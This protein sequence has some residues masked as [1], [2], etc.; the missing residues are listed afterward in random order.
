[1]SFSPTV[2]M[3]GIQNTPV[4]PVQNLPLDFQSSIKQGNVDLVTGLITQGLSVNQPLPNGEMPLHFAVRL[5]KPDVALTLLKLG[6]DPEIKDFQHLSAIDHAALMKNESMLA[7]I[8]GYKI[9]KDLKEVQEQIKCKGSASHVNQLKNKI[10]KIST[11]DVQKLT[12]INKA[13]YQGNLDELTKLSPQTI[14]EF[15]ANG[16]TPIHYA[17]LAGRSH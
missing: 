17:I 16:L 1:M 3:Q 2:N 15:D 6:A 8:L 4:I 14:N 10:Q 13:A 11:V 9:G 7:N 12:P 5:N